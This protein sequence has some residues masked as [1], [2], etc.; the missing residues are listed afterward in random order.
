MILIGGEISKVWRLIRRT[1]ESAWT[2]P[3][4]N[5]EV[6]LSRFSLADLYLRGA[7]ALALQDIFA[8]P[9]LSTSGRTAAQFRSTQ[10]E[11]RPRTDR[12][13]V[14]LV[15]KTSAGADS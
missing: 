10:L 13:E 12:N 11:G 14:A 9:R 3:S 15:G 5:M 7:V 8:G 1:V 6:R 4:V 2:S